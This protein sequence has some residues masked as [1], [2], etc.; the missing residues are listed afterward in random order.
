[1]VNG[2]SPCSRAGSRDSLEEEN[3]F[4]T[5]MERIPS[6][7]TEGSDFTDS[8]LSSLTLKKEVGG[9]KALWLQE[10][11]LL[12]STFTCSIMWSWANLYTHT[13]APTLCMNSL[14][15]IFCVRGHISADQRDQ[16]SS[17]T[18][19]EIPACQSHM[20]SH[21]SEEL[22]EPLPPGPGCDQQRSC[23]SA[24]WNF[25]FKAQSHGA[26]KTRR[27]QER[28]ERTM[29]NASCTDASPRSPLWRANK[30]QSQVRFHY[31]QLYNPQLV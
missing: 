6:L 3:S 28:S 22:C 9:G 13:H 2:K 17:I 20:F 26:T 15:S 30:K 16:F 19:A 8:I 7:Q 14:R 21:T 25:K 27:G 1:M 31:T 24:H 10:Q 29:P 11:I 12:H 4:G 23:C 5:L 18:Y